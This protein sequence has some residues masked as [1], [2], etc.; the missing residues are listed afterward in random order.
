MSY[1]THREIQ[2]LSCLLSTETEKAYKLSIEV[3]HWKDAASNVS[4]SVCVLEQ[5]RDKMRKAMNDLQSKRLK[6]VFKLSQEVVDLKK[7]KEM[8][9]QEVSQLKDTISQL[10]KQINT[11]DEVVPRRTTRR[12]SNGTQVT[13]DS[14]LS[15]S[16]CLRSRSSLS[17]SLRSSLSSSTSDASSE[18]N[19]ENSA[20]GD[21][22]VRALAER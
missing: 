17:S 5:Q 7:A 3:T 15:D 19:V 14:S 4:K 11:Q 12:V 9:L 13:E 16:F 2:R 21:L 6:R 22:L 8:H 1:I 10:G 20:L 18:A